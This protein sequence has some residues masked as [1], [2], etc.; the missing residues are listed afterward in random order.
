MVMAG[1]MVNGQWRA[2]STA[3]VIYLHWG[4]AIDLSSQLRNH[5]IAATCL[6]QSPWVHRWPGDKVYCRGR[7]EALA[8][9]DLVGDPSAADCQ[10]LEEAP[11]ASRN[12]LYQG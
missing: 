3:M 1:H 5:L 6:Y 4:W 8:Q 7:L 11:G 9:G 10:A 2:N 12:Y